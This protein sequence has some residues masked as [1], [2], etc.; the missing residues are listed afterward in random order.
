MAGERSLGWVGVTGGSECGNDGGAGG[1]VDM[2]A[3]MV[4][5]R[6]RVWGRSPAEAHGKIDLAGQ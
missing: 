1:H 3:G 4:R 2:G 6:L 5:A